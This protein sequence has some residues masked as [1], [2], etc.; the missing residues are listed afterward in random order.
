MMKLVMLRTLSGRAT[1]TT[2]AHRESAMTRI[3]SL[4]GVLALGACYA[5]AAPAVQYTTP[6]PTMVAGPPGGGMDRPAYAGQYQD[7]NGYQDPNADGAPAGP[8][9][10]QD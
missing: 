5:E 1:G 3:P 8:Y 10:G 9:A 7:P 4:L 6:E 2:D